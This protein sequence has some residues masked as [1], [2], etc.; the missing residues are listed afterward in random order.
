MKAEDPIQPN[1]QDELAYRVAYLIAGY[2]RETLTQ[3]EHEELDDWVTTSMDNQRLFEELTD[4]KNLEQWLRWKDQLPVAQVLERLKGQLAFTPEPRRFRLHIGWPFAMAAS[5]FGI[6]LVSF[7]VFQKI[8]HHRLSQPTELLGKQDIAPGASRAILTLSD[9][10][11]I[12]LDSSKKGR[13]AQQ[14][15]VVISKTDSGSIGYSMAADNH[16]AAAPLFNTIATPK[17]GEY[18]LMLPDGTKVWLNAVSSLRYPVFFTGSE[19]KVE[20]SGE[21][22]FEVTKNVTRPFVVSANGTTIQV[23]G[24]HFNV[25]AYSD[26]ATIKVT[27]SEGSVR[28]VPP[29][30]SVKNADV[31]LIPG[32]QAQVDPSGRITSGTADLETA[33]AW[34]DGL[35]V[36]KQAPIEEVLHQVSRW[37]DAD[38]DDR[39]NIS[40]HFNATIP[41]NVPVS[42]L[43][44]LLEGTGS[45]HFKIDDKKITVL[46]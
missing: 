12:L 2:I 39:V 27:L 9:G 7:L 8:A 45:V 24:T 1:P 25:N 29:T 28:V 42:K 21:G 41:R 3:K 18:Q 37:Y 13:L 43:L 4:E 40:E 36:F 14:G 38:I 5:V 30:T 34:K 16:P 6:S 22:Y 31:R 11:T 26:E 44:H 23:L 19:R 20:L 17:G 32:Q 33:L 10:T 35:F 15:E 46:K